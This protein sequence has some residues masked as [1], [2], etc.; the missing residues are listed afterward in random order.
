M[1]LSGPIAAAQS[2]ESAPEHSIKAAYLY[3]FASYAD[4]PPSALGSRD[5]PFAVG[6]LGDEQVAAELASMTRDREVHGRPIEVRKLQDSEHLAGLH[7]LFIARDSAAALARLRDAA[8]EHSVLLVTERDGSL[9]A[10]SVINFRLVDQRVLFEVSLVAAGESGL[11]IS[12]RM[13]AFAERVVTE[14]E[15]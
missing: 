11:S 14:D 5:S 7:M 9:E 6:V 8:R 4:W 13:L 12:S 10:G 15:E 3:N 1:L 2:V